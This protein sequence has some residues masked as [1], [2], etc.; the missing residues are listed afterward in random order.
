MIEGPAR[1]KQWVS[2]LY[3]VIWSLLIFVTIPLARALQIFVSRQWGREVFTYAVMAAILVALAGAAVYVRRILWGTPSRYFWLLSVAAIFFGYTIKLGMKAPEEAIHF[4][5]YGVLGI[6]TYRALTHR[7]PDVSIYIAAAIIGGIIGTV[8]EIIQW[9]TPK[10]YWGLHD[11]WF[12]FFAASLVQ[13]SIAK[14]LKPKFIAGRPSRANLRFLCGLTVAA[15]A[16]FGASLMNTPARIAWYAERI[17]RLAFLKQNES[18][19]LEYGYH[20]DDPD[21]G[22]FRSRLP[23][24][25]LKKTDRQR[26][27]EAAEILDRYRDGPGYRKFLKI[28]TPV[29]DPFLHEARVHLFRRD[30]Y[31]N[32][33]TRHKRNPEKYAR[34]LTLAFRENQILEKYFAHTLRHSA[35]VWSAQKL[36]LARKH[37]LRNEV[38]TSAVSKSLVTG[39]SETQI[40]SFF[41]LLIL[42][43]TLLHWYLGK[44]RSTR[45]AYPNKGAG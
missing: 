4:I 23:P 16:L 45:C 41:V 35:Y 32:T 7:L 33:A 27:T 29:S 11:I 13:I 9:L 43:L 44:H 25:Q 36:A 31:F 38:Y 5:Q 12:N 3:V 22:K 1:E 28:Y 24:E 10:R 20:Y 40:G 8:D 17:P 21:I 39:I 19:M 34:H 42:G 6:L 2:W 37:L 26:A 18:V 15:I 14:G 30:I